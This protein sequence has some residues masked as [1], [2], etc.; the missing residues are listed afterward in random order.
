MKKCKKNQKSEKK[1]KKNQKKVKNSKKKSDSAAVSDMDTEK[2]RFLT[3]EEKKN[4][5]LRGTS[6]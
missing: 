3:S 2:V 4:I 5:V 1:T 6:S